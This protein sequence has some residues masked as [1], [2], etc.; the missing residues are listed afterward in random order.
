[1]ATRAQA[2]RMQTTRVIAPIVVGVVV[3][4][5]WQLAVTYGG[6]SDYLLPSPAAILEKVVEF[7]ESM[8]SAGIITG[9]NALVGL[10]MGAVFGIVLALF[11]AATRLIDHMAAPIVAALAVI[12]IVALAPVLNTMFGA[13]SQVGRQIIASLAVFV[14]VFI[15]TLRGLRQTLPVHRDLMTAYAA[16]PRQVMTTVTLPTALPFIFTGI[17][18]GASLAVISALVAEYFGGPRG[19]LGGLISTSAASSAYPRAWAYVLVS[20]FIGLT[21][22]IVTLAAERVAVRRRL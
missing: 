3:L 17:R 2:A 9:T 19:G 14:P 11:A 13:D 21:F 4:G 5:A 16:S 22:Y 10:I 18:I 8:I 15:N 7:S 12:P 1:M 6:V 20:I